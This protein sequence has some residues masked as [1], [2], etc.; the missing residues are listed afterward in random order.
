MKG[1]IT[2]LLAGILVMLMCYCPVYAVVPTVETPDY[3]VAYY[4][5]DCY[6]MQDENGKKYGYGYDMMQ[7]LA[8]YLQCTFSYVGYEKTAK[9]CEEML[10]NGKPDIYTAAKI[11]P[12]REAEFAFSKHPAITSKT[13]V[14]VK[15]GNTKV[16]AGDVSTYQGLRIGLLE[17][18]TYNDRFI[19]YTKDQ[20]IDCEILYYETPTELSNAL[21]NG[22]VDALVNSYI[23]TPEDET[24][25]EDFGE[26]P[27]YFMARKE[28]QYLMD[29]IDAAIDE[30]NIETPNWRTDLYNQYYGSQNS[31]TELTEAE[32]AFLKQ[33]QA[34]QTVIRG[35]MTPDRNPY[36]WYEDEKGRGIAADIFIATAKELGLNYELVSVSLK[37]EYQKLVSSGDVD[38]C[39]DMNSY[40]E[41]EGSYKYKLTAPYLTTTISVLHARGNSGKMGKIGI[42]ED[43]IAMKEI[44]YSMWPSADILTFDSTDQCAE[45]V[46]AGKVDGVLLMS[47][48][49]QILAREDTQNRFSVDIVPGASLELKMGVNSKS[50]RN[51]YGIWEKT[52]SEVA[53][54]KSSEL[55]LNY[56]EAVSTPNL[57]AYLFD[58]LAYFAGILLFLFFTLF[59][60][61]TS[62]QSTRAK[63]KQLR[64]SERLSEALEEAQEANDAKVNFFSK[65]SHDIQT[66]LNVV[67]GMTQIAKKYKHDPY[68]LDNALDNIT[69]EG[70]YLLT[71][72][73]SILDVNQLEHGH[74]ELIHKPFCPD[75]CVRESVEI[76]QPLAK[77][78]E[79]DLTLTCNFKEHVVVGDAGRFSQ[80]MVNIISNTIKY[81]NSGGK[82]GVTLE[83]LPE[84]HYRFTCT[85]NGIGMEPEFLKHICEDYSRAEDSSGARI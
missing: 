15:R 65:M 4:G 81:T 28:D 13:C 61:W 56:L 52:L 48:T 58:H 7:S 84:N 44:L 26:T 30:M 64:I 43:N 76:L 72:I 40:Y 39:L 83:V 25:I 22:E 34:D 50:N 62:I 14:N 17:R 60:V 10:R 1:K 77:K 16:I 74:I 73:N 57:P 46:A 37:E 78:K 51:F 75:E 41:D 79:Q 8:N 45:A 21:I 27:Y 53:V 23:R 20:G 66:P 85:D 35:V 24:T 12:E 2:A 18:H 11:T 29:E 71:M 19:E 32:S 69:S 80:I 9:E 68:K 82:I 67:L 70:N 5:F 55:V 33:M 63:N 59:V 47:Y 38:V 31:N 49:A 6:H 42:M 36:S 54:N 3:K